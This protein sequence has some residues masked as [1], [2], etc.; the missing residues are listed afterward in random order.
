MYLL[1]NRI[2]ENPKY[3][4]LHHQKLNFHQKLNLP[5]LAK[6]TIHMIKLRTPV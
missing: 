1:V 2:I 6:G 4:N 5:Y 3:L